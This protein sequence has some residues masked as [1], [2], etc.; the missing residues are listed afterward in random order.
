MDLEPAQGV[1]LGQFGQELRWAIAELGGFAGHIDLDEHA[2]GSGVDFGAAIQFFGEAQAV[3]ALNHFERLDGVTG[4]VGLQVPDEVPT[5]RTRAL[6][7]FGSSFLNPVFP[8]KTDTQV[9]DGADRFGRMILAHRHEL[10]GGGVASGAVAGG[11]DA[12]LDLFQALGKVHGRTVAANRPYRNRETSRA[13]VMAKQYW[14]VKQEPSDY[15]WDAFQKDG[16]TAWT[17]VRSY[18]ARLHLRAMSEGD[19]VA[20]YH[21]GEGKE[22]VGVAK[23][24]RTA[25]PDPTADEGDWT[26]VDL[27]PVRPL[28]AAVTLTAIKADRLLK[29]M[30][31]VKQSRLSVMPVT[32]DQWERLMEMGKGG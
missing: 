12:S 14:L 20:Y 10:H 17:G 4:L 16:R 5:E 24:I 22:V 15:A 19:L 31:L 30:A 8:K 23:V 13:R 28:K 1:E 7:D 29:E 11:T 25:Y 32:P 6:G 27:A 26:A 9:G 18:P 3:D 21:S 2:E